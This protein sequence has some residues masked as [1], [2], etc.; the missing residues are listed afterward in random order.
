MDHNNQDFADLDNPEEIGMDV[1]N[2]IAALQD[3]GKIARCF[4][5]PTLS[6]S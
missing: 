1:A 6:R 3:P 2:C 4:M 5:A